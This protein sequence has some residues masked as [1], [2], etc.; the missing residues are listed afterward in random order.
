MS[1]HSYYDKDCFLHIPAQLS[2]PSISHYVDSRTTR[3]EAKEGT[4]LTRGLTILFFVTGNPGC[5]SFYHRFLRLLVTEP[6][7]AEQQARDS[8]SEAAI[9]ERLRSQGSYDGLTKE[10]SQCVVAGFSLAGFESGPSAYSPGSNLSSPLIDKPELFSKPPFYREII[11]SGKV[12]SLQEQILISLLR[13]R[14]LVQALRSEFAEQT[15]GKRLSVV[16]MGHSVGAYI[17]LEMTRLWK[18]QAT[19]SSKPFDIR[20]LF[21]LTPTIH[22]ISLSSSGRV[23][24]PALTYL[25]FLPV[26]AQVIASSLGYLVSESTIRRL[27]SWVLR[28]D[29]KSPRVDMLLDFL[30]SKGAVRQALSM[31]TNEMQEI[32]HFRLKGWESF[33]FSRPITA[34]TA[35]ESS[36]KVLADRGASAPKL[37]LL[38][39]HSDHWV[40]EE[41]REE[42]ITALTNEDRAISGTTGDGTPH[43]SEQ[44]SHLST[45]TILVEQDGGLRHAWCLDEAETDN[46]VS[47]VRSWVAE[48]VNRLPYTNPCS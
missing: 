44:S 15:D 18:E 35:A 10:T 19:D 21:L 34:V 36:S 20:S 13:L 12:Y 27:T 8:S 37:Y 46:V 30:R 4:Q 42:I 1:L 5:L 7:Q 43:D 2:N 25:P 9:S 38:F 32:G 45:S 17:A 33:V 28:V 14:L 29:S 39:A 22:N 41:T 40:A 6:A 24:T 16:L 31:A 23:F 47:R 48:T 26:A 11:E 3:H